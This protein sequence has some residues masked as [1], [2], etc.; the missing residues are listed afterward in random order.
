MKLRYEENFNWV[1]GENQSSR[2]AFPGTPTV[3]ISPRETPRNQN[4][5]L[6]IKELCNGFTLCINLHNWI[7][8]TYF[9]ASSFKP[10]IY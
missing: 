6:I 4:E 7:I 2:A 5:K 8:T 9:E 3:F 1:N 10:T